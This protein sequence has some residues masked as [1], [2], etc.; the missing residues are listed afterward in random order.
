MLSLFAG[1]V[2]VAAAVQS[3]VT[4]SDY[5][6]LLIG[7]WGGDSDSSPITSTETAVI[8]GMVKTKTEK[9]SQM[10]LLLGDNFYS[11]GVSSSTAA[12]RFKSGFENAFSDAAWDQMPFYALCGNHDHRGSTSEQTQYTG[13]GS[14]RWNMPSLNYNID[15]TL[16]DGKTLRIVMFDSVELVGQNYFDEGGA[17]VEEPPPNETQFG[18]ASANWAW[19]EDQL[20]SWD[21]D[22]LFTAAHYPVHS[23]CSHG[24]VLRGKS[25]DTYMTTYN[26]NGHLAGHDH[27]LMHIEEGT[28][29]HVLTG[30]GADNWYSWSSSRVQSE[31]DVKWYMAS[32]NTNNHRGGYTGLTFNSEG[33]HFTYYG[34]NGDVLYESTPFK[35]RKSTMTV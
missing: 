28:Q 16:P 19:I 34:E 12:T 3:N 27:C 9:N 30:A 17:Q 35:S 20:K 8:K 10:V 2:G 4:S 1:F 33:G 18:D 11:S 23:G 25:H 22:Y 13:K 29:Q 14:G 7:D 31:A 15:R 26:V 6:V 5:H 32:G 24:S 21:G